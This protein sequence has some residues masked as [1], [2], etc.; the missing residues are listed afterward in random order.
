MSPLA[1]PDPLTV[2][3]W[4]T[5]IATVILA[6]GAIIT[7]IFAIRAFGK[8]SEELGV[9]QQQANDQQAL[10]SQ[11]GELLKIQSGQLELQRQQLDNQRKVNEQQAGVLELQAK[12]LQES[13]DERKRDR[14]QQRR[15][16]ASRVFPTVG[17]ITGTPEQYYVAV[18]NASD[19]PVYNLTLT[20]HSLRAAEP[21]ALSF[22]S[23]AM[24]ALMPGE[25]KRIPS[26]GGVPFDAT[27]PGGVWSKAWFRDANEVR[28]TVTSKGEISELR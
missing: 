22:D 13:V 9:L 20:L 11:Q 4:V 23:E 24:P 3:T 5:A 25:I 17:V 6:L 18:K 12:E 16:Q 8:Q 28:W 1:A 15:D 10:T 2:P 21:V 19:R 27:G 26:A 14:E 7:S